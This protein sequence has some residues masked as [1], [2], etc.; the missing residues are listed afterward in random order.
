[1]AGVADTSRDALFEISNG[2]RAQVTEAI[3]R[4]VELAGMRGGRDGC[5]M[6]EIKAAILQANSL[7]VDMSTISGRVA[8]LVKVKRLRRQAK[9]RLC[10]VTGQSIGPLE[11]VPLVDRISGHSGA[12]F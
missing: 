6:R 3:Y 10:R 9:K 7:D 12:T 1:M 11:V 8:E 4:A 2:R 5:S